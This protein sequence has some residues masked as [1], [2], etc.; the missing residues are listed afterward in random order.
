[1]AFVMV[2]NFNEEKSKKKALKI[3]KAICFEYKSV[4]VLLF[5]F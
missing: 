1:M 3:R 4:I 2:A 5:I